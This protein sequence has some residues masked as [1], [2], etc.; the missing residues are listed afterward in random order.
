MSTHAKFSPSSSSRWL[1]CS[2][3][4]NVT[5]KETKLDSPYAK[6]G[7]ALHLM[8]EDILSGKEP[9]LFY[10]DYVPT[11]K[12]IEE[13]VKPYIDYVAKVKGELRLYEQELF[14]NEDC[15]GTADALVYDSETMTLNIIDL[16]CG[17]G[18]YVSVY[19][20]TQLQIYAIGAV[21]KILSMNKPVAN[22]FVHI[23]QP[24]KNNFEKEQIKLKDLLPLEKKINTIISNYKNG[25]FN[26]EVGES[27][28]R[29]C[30]RVNTCPEIL[31]Q[32]QKAAREDFLTIPLNER[33]DMTP[34]IKIFIKVTEEE[35]MNTLL[36]GGNIDTYHLVPG[37]KTRS[38]IDEK[39][40]YEKLW[41]LLGASKVVETKTEML[42]VAKIE[43]EIK[44]Q[45][46]NIDL[47][48]L[49]KSEATTVVISK[50]K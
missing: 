1:N 19:G 18:I 36:R 49:I 30:P 16:K 29:W 6:K 14:V 39:I 37:R 46:L 17:E 8:S 33:L 38:W 43:K 25:I 22:V 11:Q 13:I 31:K 35:A 47:D 26:F 5:Q 50:I 3:S 12:D 48:E 15:F 10:N 42:S 23:V 24:L 32:A 2:Q 21:K 20:N 27:Y 44:A 7:T 40:A 9:K 41:P 34:A 4:L 45:K 28:C